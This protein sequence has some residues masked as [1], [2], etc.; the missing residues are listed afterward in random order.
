MKPRFLALPGLVLVAG[1]I[2]AG[3]QQ[4]RSAAVFSHR[5]EDVAQLDRLLSSSNELDA[6]VLE[7]RG[8]IALN[9]DAIDRAVLSLRPAARAAAVLRGRGAAYAEAGDALERAAEELRKTESLL[10]AF[11]TDLALLR[12][13][14]RYFPIAA[15]ALS[16][17]DDASTSHINAL[18]ADLGRF[19]GASTPE[20]G[21]RMT[22][23]LA[24]LD[25]AR[26]ER[27]VRTSRVNALRADVERYQE[28]P[29]RE[30]AQRLEGEISALE[31]SRPLF[32]PA[33]R[34]DLDIL[35]GHTRAILDRRERVDRTARAVVHSALQID[36]EAAR[37]AYERSSRHEY[38]AASAL[39][40]VTLELCAAAVALLAA[41]FGWFVALR[42]A[43]RPG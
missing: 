19:E 5:G 4:R 37:A 17:P 2:W 21:W 29:A 34:G 25:A 11:K 22:G 3:V 31:E 24:G 38:A 7:A 35:L 12:L 8:G 15:G 6:N 30:I 33:S 28:V 14:S 16:R 39:R 23:A 10:E 41:A 20:V 9:F 26:K 36:L 27:E 32:A 40:L 1:A 18:R 13:S 42:R 43:A